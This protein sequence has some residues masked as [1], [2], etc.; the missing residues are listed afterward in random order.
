MPVSEQQT[1]SPTD[2]AYLLA[3]RGIRASR[4]RIARMGNQL[5]GRTS[6]QYGQ[7]RRFAATQVD[8]LA[9]AFLLTDAGL[10]REDAARMVQDPDE[11]ANQIQAEADTRIEALRRL[12]APVKAMSA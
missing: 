3:Q 10:S 6:E 9:A 7:H 4:D 12:Q 11:A 5:Y 8:E 1:L 2:V